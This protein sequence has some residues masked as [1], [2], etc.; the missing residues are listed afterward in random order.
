MFFL[1]LK[2]RNELRRFLVRDTIFLNFIIVFCACGV[3]L[4]LM[5]MI[6]P[7][8]FINTEEIYK[9]YG[10]SNE[11]VYSRAL[12]KTKQQSGV[13]LMIFVM[14]GIT[15]CMIKLAFYK[16]KFVTR[17]NKVKYFKAYQNLIYERSLKQFFSYKNDYFP[18]EV[19][20]VSEIVSNNKEAV[21]SKRNNE[22]MF[23][24]N[25]YFEG[26]V[27]GNATVFGNVMCK[28]TYRHKGSTQVAVM[29]NAFTIS[30]ELFADLPSDFRL[31][32]I[33]DRTGKWFGQLLQFSKFDSD[34]LIKIQDRKLERR[35]KVY[36]NDPSVAAIYLTEARRDVL[37]NWKTSLDNRLKLTII[38][39]R[40]TVSFPNQ[41]KLLFPPMHK[42]CTLERFET[43]KKILEDILEQLQLFSNKQ[44]SIKGH[45]V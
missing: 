18:I 7:S 5:Q 10:M 40:L 32:L 34:T 31:K 17:F 41:R 33:H 9:P 35:F 1:D 16:T 30:I 2:R 42:K 12:S 43:N 24:S 38:G 29:Y 25:G 20:R 3:L 13:W 23:L 19:I 36:S 39:N 26:Y 11:E 8:W 22:P 21:V 28:G 27:N 4:F 6:L 44:E 45:A 37:K 14:L 15:L